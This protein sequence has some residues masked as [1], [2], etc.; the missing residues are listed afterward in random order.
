MHV[1]HIGTPLMYTEQYTD[2]QDLTCSTGAGGGLAT[3][4]EAG[5]WGASLGPAAHP[6]GGHRDHV[7]GEP[8]QG[9]SSFPRN[10]MQVSKDPF[11]PCSEQAV[12]V[13]FAVS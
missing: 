7:P 4:V 2:R 9:A 1:A 8:Y 5:Y 13:R 11:A 10:L 12:T 6:Q 3:N